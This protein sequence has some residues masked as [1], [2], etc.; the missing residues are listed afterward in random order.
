MFGFYA[1]RILGVDVVEEADK[2]LVTVRALTD[3]GDR[4]REHLERREQA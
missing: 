4:S 1:I 2:L 3:A